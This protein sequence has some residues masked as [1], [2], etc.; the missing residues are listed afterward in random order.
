MAIWLGQAGGIRIASAASDR[1]FS[2]I[3][4]ANIDPSVN[5]FFFDNGK[6]TLSTGDFVWIRRVDANGDPEGMLDFISGQAWSDSTQHP[7]GQWFV[8][9]D[10]VGGI[11]LYED[12][13]D[14]VNDTRSNAISLQAISSGYRVSYQVMQ[15]AEE[16]LGQTISWT[17]NTDREV[18]DFTSLGDGFRQNMATLVSGS[19]ELDCF[20][21]LASD[22]ACSEEEGSMPSLYLH[23]LALRQEI[24][25][26][27]TGVF[28]MKQV[29]SV[30]LNE[31]V[32]KAEAVKEL[33][34][35]AECV[36]TA[37]ASELSPK[38][39]IHSRI[40]FVTTGP[41]QLLFGFPSGYL[42]QEEPPNDKV[43]QETDF[44][45]LLETPA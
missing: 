42:L 4:P 33:F 37:I 35:K 24:G 6:V 32:D 21:D 3:D 13:T 18:A 17:L 25:A 19:G 43:M 38:E 2:G 22:R 36:V 8:N 14:A 26:K 12:W 28:L 20:F 10:A 44:G 45:I 41:I 1:M 27:F 16:C 40:T 23:Q 5:R 34:Y 29:G 39:P 15:G 9:A 7:D 30:P 11:R 31:L